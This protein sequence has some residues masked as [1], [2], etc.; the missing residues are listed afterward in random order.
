MRTI[1]LLWPSRTLSKKCSAL[2]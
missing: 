2:L 1:D